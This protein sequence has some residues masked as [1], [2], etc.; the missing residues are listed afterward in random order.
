MQ[1][2]SLKKRYDVVVFD[3]YGN[4]TL[5]VE[6]KAPKI[7]ITQNTFDQIAM[8]NM[9]LKATYLMV[10]NGLHHFY[11]QMDPVQEKYHFLEG[12]PDFSR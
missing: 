2:N 6:C 5:L 9:Q 7:T 11:C 4:I 3:P 12:I 8:Y 10:T 1:L